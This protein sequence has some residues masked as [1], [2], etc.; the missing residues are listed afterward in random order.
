MLSKGRRNEW[1]SAC[2]GRGKAGHHVTAGL[3]AVLHGWSTQV[4]VLRARAADG[5]SRARE[6]G[7]GAGTQDHKQRPTKAPAAEWTKF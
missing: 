6:R 5:Q 4:G 3:A 7:A 1:H 2:W